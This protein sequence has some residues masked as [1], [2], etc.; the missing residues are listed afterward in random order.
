MHMCVR[1]CVHA[2]VCRD[3]QGKRKMATSKPKELKLELEASKHSLTIYY[4][5]G[6]CSAQIPL[7]HLGK[8]SGLVYIYANTYT[9]ASAVQGGQ[10]Q[11][12]S[13]IEEV[14]AGP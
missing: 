6:V 8:L 1:E 12:K 2:C 14:C 5:L 3:L 11:R 7:Y 4:M 10:C 9:A 13:F